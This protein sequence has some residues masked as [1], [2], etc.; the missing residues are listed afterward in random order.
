MRSKLVELKR[1]SQGCPEQ[2]EGKT[3]DGKYVFA[4]ERHGYVRVEVDDLIVLERPGDSA[5][6]ALAEKFDLPDEVEL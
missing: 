2:W 6:D 1:I 3:E 5:Y 4:R